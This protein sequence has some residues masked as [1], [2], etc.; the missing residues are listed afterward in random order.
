MVIANNFVKF[1]FLESL[2]YNWIG[3]KKEK[4]KSFGFIVGTK[5]K[6]LSLCLFANYYTTIT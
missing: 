3:K 4:E 5:I 2:S 1:L 6:S